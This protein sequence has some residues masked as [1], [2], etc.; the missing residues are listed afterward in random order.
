MMRL[1]KYKIKLTDLI[2]KTSEYADDVLKPDRLKKELPGRINQQLNNVLELENIGYWIKIPGS[3]IIWF[4]DIAARIIGIKNS[5]STLSADNFLYNIYSEDRDILEQY[6]KEPPDN[7]ES[8]KHNFRL[9][10]FNSKETVE[11][12][13]SIGKIRDHSTNKE[14]II[15]TIRDITKQEKFKREITRLKEK[16]EESTAQMNIF[17]AN[18]SHEI[19]TPLNSIIGFSELLNIGNLDAKTRTE[20]FKI[21][22][23]QGHLLQKLVDDISELSKY[24]AGDLKINKSP[25]NFNLLLNELLIR[26]RQQK[27]QLNKDNVDVKIKLPDNQEIIGYTDSGRITQILSNLTTTSLF[28]TDRGYIEIGYYKTEEQKLEFYVKDTGAGFTREEQKYMFDR[29]SQAQDTVIRK[30][31]GLGISLTVSRGLVK[32]LGG[33]IWI[34]SEP[35]SGST[36]YFQIPFEEIPQT[37]SHEEAEDISSLK[38]HKWKDKLILV[39]EDDEVNY[40]F[41]EAV[42][43]NTEAQ[44]IKA[45]NGYQAV[46]LCKSINKIDLVLMDLKLPDIS[47]FE[48]TRQIRKFNKAVPIIA[49]TALIL[50]SEKEKCINSGFNN[51]ITKP[52]EIE[53]LLKIISKYLGE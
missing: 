12:S 32:L 31:E 40:K 15:G 17:L 53:K 42:L 28:Y 9:T 29:L 18:I 8:A 37:D 25:C 10:K 41:L 36:F 34:E 47:G 49:Q 52:I 20:Y 3:N 45:D 23:N 2:Y 46:D 26:V 33:R 27:K 22:I 1:R 13:T 5:E 6:L 4:S 21:I 35:G 7:R 16:A 39:V 24:E 19:R 48:A 11:L 51:Q 38:R 30:F 44:V 43:Q 50:E 14:I